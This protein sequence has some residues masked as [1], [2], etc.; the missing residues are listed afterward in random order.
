MTNIKFDPEH[1]KVL[2][3]FLLEIPGVIP[4]KMFGYPAYYINKK[5]FACLYEN[6]VGIKVPE[7]KAN[8]L[9]G[10]KGIIH[11]QPLGRAKM[12]EWI[13]I[14]RKNSVDYLKDQEI[15][16]ISVKFVSKLD[17]SQN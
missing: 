4:G 2:D 7:D 17:K 11:F 9:I 12:R 14:N 15:F 6:G 5:L 16:D 13:Q 1:K 8:E 3:S 10:K